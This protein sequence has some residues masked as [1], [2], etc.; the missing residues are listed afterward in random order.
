MKLKKLTVLTLVLVFAL[1]ISAGAMLLDYEEEFGE[2]D[3]EGEEVTYVMF[4]DH[5]EEFEEGGDYAGRLEEAKEK[6]NIGEIEYLHVGWGDEA[7]EM[8]MSRLL[9]GDSNYDMWMLPHRNVWSMSTQGAFYPL[10][11][12]LPQEYFDN[13][14]PDMESITETL[15]YGG[16][17]YSVGLGEDHYHTLV[18]L[19]WNKDIFDREG[20]TPLDELYEQGDL[21]WNAVE[22]IARQVTRDTS[23][24]GEIDQWGFGDG[25]VLSFVSSN[26]VFPTTQ[27][28]DGNVVFDYNSEEAVTALSRMQEWIQDDLFGGS[29]ERTEFRDGVIAMEIHEIWEFEETMEEMEDD[30]GAVP[31]PRGPHADDHVYFA[32]NLDGFYLP[33]NSEDPAAM[34]ALHNFLYPQEEWLEDRETFRIE[35]APDELTYQVMK[36]AEQEWDGEAYTMQGILGDWWDDSQPFG[37]AVGAI[38]YGGD[39][40][41]T[42][43][44]AAAQAIQSDLDSMFEQ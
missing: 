23:G 27:D 15:S 26:D 16:E 29:W 2:I 9:G 41:A 39:D 19:A 4:Y 38:M 42:T 3:F 34:I 31:M 11:E 43:M 8:M 30:W 5:F 40:A 35:Y 13:M 7:E 10:N 44:D 14:S 25:D 24:D 37:G 1:S 32:N 36:D 18:Y 6:F 17:T 22:D 33:A 21:T 28:E 20:M 12:V